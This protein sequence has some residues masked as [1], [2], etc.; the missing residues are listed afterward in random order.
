MGSSYLQLYTA[1]TISMLLH[2]WCMFNAIHS[3][4]GEFRFFMAQPLAITL[5]DFVQ[6]CWRRTGLSERHSKIGRVAG[7]TW[8]FVWFSYCL[9]PFVQSQRAVGI[10][11]EDSGAEWAMQLAQRHITAV[12]TLGLTS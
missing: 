2:E 11:Q 12:I 8:M 1:F 6:W 9:P 5:E 4:A 10:M 7:Y 3:D